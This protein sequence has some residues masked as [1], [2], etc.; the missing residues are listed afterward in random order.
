MKDL[1]VL[2]GAIAQFASPT[3][4]RGCLD[5]LRA[6]FVLTICSLLQAQQHRAVASANRVTQGPILN[7]KVTL[8]GLTVAATIVY[9]CM[10]QIHY[11]A[12]MLVIM[13]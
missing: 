13:R 1:Q 10:T 8:T 12:L 9:T 5:L 2:M 6:E 7:V 11:T 3:H 4:S